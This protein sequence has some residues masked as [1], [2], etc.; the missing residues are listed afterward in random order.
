MRIGEA[1]RL[2]RNDVDLE[3]GV[4]EV[5]NT[6]FHKSRQIAIYPSTTKALLEYVVA[7]EQCQPCPNSKAF[8]LSEQ[9]KELDYSAVRYAFRR[10]CR[11]LG[12]R[13]EGKRN[14]PRI[15]DIRSTFACRRI[16]LWCRN[17]FDVEHGIAAL[18]THMGHVRVTDTYWYLTGVPELMQIAT[19]RFER[20]VQNNK[21]R[22]LS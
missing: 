18:S 14:F 20:F 10:I 5:I 11:R 19:Q 3:Q 22:F 2:Q 6:K 13:P 21:K 7:R 12:L 9:G 1:L 17:E 16:L 4:L 8:F 15:Y